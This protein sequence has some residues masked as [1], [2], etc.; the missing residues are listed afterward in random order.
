MKLLIFVCFIALASAHPY[1]LGLSKCT[2][3]PAYWCA[4]YAQAVE[5]QAI[6]HCKNYVW[7]KKGADD[8]DECKAAIEQ[9]HTLFANNGSKLLEVMK[10][11]CT[12]LNV[13]AL[14][15]KIAVDAYGSQ[16][17]T[18]LEQMTYGGEKLCQEMRICSSIE[19]VKI[20]KKIM[21]ANFKSHANIP[22]LKS[23]SADDCIS[24]KLVFAEVKDLLQSPDIQKQI[25]SEVESLCA[26]LGAFA[27]QCKSYVDEILPLVFTEIASKIVPAELCIELGFCHNSTIK[28]PNVVKALKLLQPQVKELQIPM[29]PAEVAFTDSYAHKSIEPLDEGK[30]EQCKMMAKKL[31]LALT[32]REDAFI[33]VLRK[34]CPS[35]GPPLNG[36]CSGAAKIIVDML[37]KSL[38]NPAGFCQMIG[39]CPS[40]D[41]EVETFETLLLNILKSHPK[42]VALASFEGKYCNYCRS[43]VGE[44]ETILSDKSVQQDVIN[45]VDTL[46]IELGSFAPVCKYFVDAYLP[47]FL[48]KLDSFMKSA[49][50]CSKLGIASR[51]VPAKKHAV[52]K[53]IHALPLVPS[54]PRAEMNVEKD[55]E[56][57]ALPLSP[58]KAEAEISVKEYVEGLTIP[59]IPGTPA[60]TEDEINVKEYV[61]GLTIPAIPGTPAKTEGEISVRE[62]IDGLTIPA[63][64]GT[65]AKTEAEISVKEYVEGLT[66]PAIPG[67]PAKTE[68]EINA[69]E[70]EVVR[71]IRAVPLIAEMDVPE[72]VEGKTYP[73]IPGTPAMT[74]SEKSVKI[75]ESGG[76]CILCEL[77][78]RELDGLLEDNA[79]ESEI[80]AALDKVCSLLPSSFSSECDKFVEDYTTKIIDFLRK[81]ISPM[82]ICSLIQLCTTE[83]KSNKVSP[84]KPAFIFCM[85]CKKIVENVDS[86]IQSGMSS[87]EV[88]EA[89]QHVCDMYP[90]F[91]KSQCKQ[92]VSQFTSQIIQMITSQVSPDRICGLLHICSKENESNKMSLRKPSFGT[93]DLCKFAVQYVDNELKTRGVEDEIEEALEEIC[94]ALPSSLKTECNALVKKYGDLLLNIIIGK[95]TP[96]EVCAELK[97][98]PAASGISIVKHK[99]I[100]GETFWCKSYENAKLCNALEYCNFK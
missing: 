30:C 38:G 13:G 44:L 62:Y 73:A 96:D 85:I 23:P 88:Q 43:A 19:H 46:C 83:S 75:G 25:I 55:E 41:D 93:C 48:E 89:I 1:R 56:V 35:L 7:K 68:N 79:T 81:E 51:G 97:L 92:F 40:T 3:G 16:I 22:S 52:G 72:Y 87:S 11:V 99:C 95:M 91:I 47:L 60:K 17:I 14:E 8:C 94:D 53:T 82:E 20:T 10:N 28:A 59:A 33:D 80:K 26:E 32:Q 21:L 4:S 31:E 65:P 12:G 42:I 9:V 98:C 2:Y 74:D 18:S 58:A 71:T 69:N 66:I 77:V 61:E 50:L 37:K 24:C 6:S 70:N 78:M 36:L 63:I 39:M 15:C 57:H 29:I 27:S 64:P 5:C 49:M 90:P 67:T 54:K 100:L 45:L 86:L 84:R 34:S 76:E